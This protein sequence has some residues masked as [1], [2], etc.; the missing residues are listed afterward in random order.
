MKEKPC[1][2]LTKSKWTRM[3]ELIEREDTVITKVDKSVTVVIVTV[4]NYITGAERQ[5]SNTDNNRKL[6]QDPTVTNMKLV[7]DT[8]KRLKKQ[9]IKKKAMVA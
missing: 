2:K 5:L 7:N 9:K 8:I 3:K 1:N 6:Q 4:K